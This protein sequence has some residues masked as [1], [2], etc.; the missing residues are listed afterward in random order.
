MELKQA[1]WYVHTCRF[2]LAQFESL[3]EHEKKNHNTYSTF[4]LGS[5]RNTRLEKK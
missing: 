5:L 3:L 4:F 2:W 1:E